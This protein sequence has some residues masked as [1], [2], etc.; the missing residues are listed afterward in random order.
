M[1]LPGIRAVSDEGLVSLYTR[2]V[3][4]LKALAENERQ[5]KASSQC[6][7]CAIDTRPIHKPHKRFMDGDNEAFQWAAVMRECPACG[8]QI[9]HTRSAQLQREDED[10][11]Y[12]V[13]DVE[14]ESRV[15][16]R[17][18]PRLVKPT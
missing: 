1:T 8:C 15:V 3:E 9:E 4:L 7:Y 11:P 2:R 13:V 18:E 16:K 6:P 12:E 14:A 5:I 17:P 10:H